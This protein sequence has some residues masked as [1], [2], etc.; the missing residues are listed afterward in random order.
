MGKVV[1]QDLETP[2]GTLRV[3]ASPNGVCRVAFPAH[4]SSEWPAWFDRHFSGSPRKGVAPTVHRALAQLSEYFQRQRRS[5][6]VPLDLRGTAFQLRV[7]RELRKIP[8]GFTVTYGEIARRIHNPRATQ[9]VGAA[10]GKNPV[11][12]I[13]PCHRVIGHDG[14]LVGFGGGLPSKEKLLELEGARIPF[15]SCS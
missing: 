12:I 9:A 8:Y 15:T 7:W 4:Q 10:V 11:P 3:A 13:V 2:I 1:W 6:D 14:S 5:F